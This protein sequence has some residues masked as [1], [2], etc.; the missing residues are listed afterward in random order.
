MT[1]T[2]E[3]VIE[4]TISNMK[5][6]AN[7]S[8]TIIQNRTISLFNT[9]ATISCMSKSCFDK[10]QPHPK[11]VRTNTYRVNGANENSLGPIGMT[12]CTLKFP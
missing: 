8:I 3:E 1:I 5:Y 4:V 10:L 2:T 6:A 9:G 7:F 11:L 12:T